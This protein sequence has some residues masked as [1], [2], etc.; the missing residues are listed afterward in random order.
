MTGGL[1]LLLIVGSFLP[2]RDALAEQAYPA[3]GNLQF[4][5][6]GGSFESNPEAQLVGVRNEYGL[7]VILGIDF[8]NVSYLG[9]D[10]ELLGVNRDFDTPISPPFLGTL[11]NDTTVETAG[12][13]VGARLFYPV[14]QSIHVYGVGGVGYYRT[15]LR[16][17][18]TL[19]GLPGV[20]EE[21][22]TS[23]EYYY[24]AGVSYDFATW[25]LGLHYRHVNLNGDF[26]GFQISNA[27]LGGDLLALGFG[28]RY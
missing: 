25:T 27:D 3:S 4:T 10:M 28:F 7:G 21:D 26:G 19:L 17:T 20:Y 1:C 8:P 18:G 11:D 9:L 5:V 13:L 24:G 2:A 15:K 12:L 23:F 16:V 14:T 22:D 6:Y